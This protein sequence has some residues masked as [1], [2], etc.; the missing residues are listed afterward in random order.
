MRVTTSRRSSSFMLNVSGPCIPAVCRKSGH[1]YFGGTGH[2]H[3]GPTPVRPCSS[4]TSTVPPVVVPTGPTHGDSTIFDHAAS[5]RDRERGRRTSDEGGGATLNSGTHCL[6][7]VDGSGGA[8][9]GA[10]GWIGEGY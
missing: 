2:L 8:R 1:L 7:F 3:F 9:A 10:R 6:T 4:V 5:G